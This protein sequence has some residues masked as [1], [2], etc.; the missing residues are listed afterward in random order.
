MT[1]FIAF[2]SFAVGGM[3]GFVLAAVLIMS[4]DGGEL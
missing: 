1:L 2:I 4:D 3:F